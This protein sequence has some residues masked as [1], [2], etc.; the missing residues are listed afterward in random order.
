MHEGP[1]IPVSLVN[2]SRTKSDIT[3]HY[4]AIVIFTARYDEERDY[5]GLKLTNSILSVISLS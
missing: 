1:V 4:I 2:G 3:V 5:D